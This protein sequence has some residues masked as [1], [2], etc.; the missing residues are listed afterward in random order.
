MFEK[1]VLS[2]NPK[3]INMNT[4]LQEFESKSKRGY[5]MFSAAGN[6]AIHGI[7]KKTM[8][9]VYGKKKVTQSELEAYIG[10]EL[11]RVSVKHG[12]AWDTEPPIHIEWWVNKALKEVGY[13]FEVNRYNF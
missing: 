2:L 13:G 12:E 6:A 7:I 3:L 8:R 9:K 10:G 1:I 11:K 4:V 5:E